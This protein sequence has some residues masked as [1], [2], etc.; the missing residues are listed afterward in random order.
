MTRLRSF[1]LAVVLGLAASVAAQ[2]A[3][4]AKTHDFGRVVEGD[5][6]VSHTFRFTN[7][8]AEPLRLVRV[9]AACGCTT[10]DWTDAA[11][12]PGASGTLA[13]VYDP[14]GRPGPFDKTVFVATEA[15]DSVVLRITGS[16]EPALARSG[17]RVGAFAF[18]AVDVDAGVVAEGEPLQTAV[19]FAHVGTRPVRIER[20]EAPAGVEVSFSDRPI[21]PDAL[22]GLFVTVPDPRRAGGG[23]ARGVR[24]DAAHDG[25]RRAGQDPPRLR[26]ARAA[27]GGVREDRRRRTEDGET[28]EWRRSPPARR[29]QGSRACSRPRSPVFRP[30]SPNHQVRRK[31]GRLGPV[32]AA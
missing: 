3:F 16:V 2:P 10:P 7:A 31:T 13:V 8:G 18:D 12:A 26:P 24:G 9:E 19:Q 29:A 22:G 15:G 6:P 20:V 14:A 30:R 23:R 5:G 27:S 25:R 1:P 21:F 28:T 17:V 4:E 32:G 11:L